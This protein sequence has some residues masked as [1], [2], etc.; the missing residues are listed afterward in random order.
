MVVDKIVDIVVELDTVPP[1]VELASVVVDIP[2]TVEFCQDD[3]MLRALKETPVVL[4]PDEKSR[5]SVP[6]SLGK[7]WVVKVASPCPPNTS[8]DDQSRRMRKVTVPPLA[9]VNGA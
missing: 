9:D 4:P 6:A 7:I 8:T 5:T 1:V 3:P 2:L